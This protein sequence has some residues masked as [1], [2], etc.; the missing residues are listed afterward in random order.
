MVDAAAL[1]QSFAQVAEHGDEVPLYFYSYLFLR[2]PQVRGLFPPT[3]AAQRD[4][5]VG[6][7]ARIVSEVDQLDSLVPFLEQLGRDHR[8]F[9]VITDHYPQVG[10]ALLATL[11]HFLGGGWTPRL[12]AE[13][14]AAY[15][16]VADVMVK[17]ATAATVQ[18]PWWDAEVVGHERRSPDLAVIT[19]LPYEELPYLPGQSISVE[20]SQRPRMWR[21]YSPANAP[22]QDRTIELHVRAIDG[23]WVSSALVMAVGVGDTVQLGPAV[24]ELVLDPRSPDELLLIASGTGLAPLR[25]ITEDL[26]ARGTDHRR[27]HLYVE[28]RTEGELYD[29]PALERL[30]WDNP[31]LTVVP[32]AELG[33]TNRAQSGSAVELALRQ[34]R[35]TRHLVYVCGAP[36]MV[37]TTRDLLARA[38]LDPT[39]VRYESFGY[40][41]GPASEELALDGGPN[42]P[43][44]LAATRGELA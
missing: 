9:Q 27:V 39:R 24:G 30:S 17:A 32:V 4:R 29:L 3:M 21:Y 36:R 34:S 20:T 42:T 31:W 38:G 26:A 14:T 7:L 1:K 5:L 6:A 16:V 19:L 35:W 33:P 23:G 13:W 22:R 12:A 8:K 18:P 37:S 11:G 15:G 44:D 25:A 2:H 43:S 41:S 40:R 10:E 28:A